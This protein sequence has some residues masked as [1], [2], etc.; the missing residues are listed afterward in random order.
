M[1]R[2]DARPGSRFAIASSPD[3]QIAV[4]DAVG[5]MLHRDDGALDVVLPHALYRVQLERAGRVTSRL[6]DH[7]DTTE[8]RL[9]GPG[10]VTPVPILGAITSHD[11][12]ADAAEQVSVSNTSAPLGPPPHDSRLFVFLRREAADRGPATLPS[13]PVTLHDVTGRKLTALGHA[14]A[15]VDQRLGYIAFATWVASGTY[16]LR[17]GR[18]R[19]DI[20]ITI[21]PGRAAHVF[22]ADD[23]EL[24]LD[25]CRIALRPVDQRF[26]RRSNTAREVEAVV[27]AL[28]ARDRALPSSAH[29]LLTSAIDDDLC[30]GI[31]AAH[32]LLRSRELSALHTL[33]L[34]LGRIADAIPDVAVLDRVLRRAAGTPVDHLQLAAPPLLRASLAL[35]MCCGQSPDVD[36]APE[37][38]VVQ[39]ALAGYHDSIWC[40]WSDRAWDRRWVEATIDALR[41]GRDGSDA[42][43]IARSIAVPTRTVHET[44]D[45]IAASLPSPGGAADP[46]APPSVP[47]YALGDVIG[48]G[49][50]GTVFRATRVADRCAV[51]LKVVP[52]SASRERRL[53]A[54]RELAL[55]RHIDHTQIV[56]PRACGMLPGDAGCWFEFE[57]CR[58][59][60]LDLLA[61]ADAA[62][63]PPRACAIALQALEGLAHLHARGIVHRDIK[64]GNLLIRADGSAAIADLGLAKL[65]DG[66][67]VSSPGTAGGT[68][69]FAPREQLL[70]FKRASPAADV[71]SM[72][73][74]LYFML[75]L[76]PPRETFTDQGELE[77]A[78]ENPVVAIEDRLP[79][80]PPLLAICIN[81]ALSIDPVGRPRD[82]AA[83]RAD[84]AAAAA[85]R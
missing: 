38:A 84:L 24:R 50:Q 52:L 61:A 25:A 68:F 67:S 80:I 64:P 66:S 76:D 20:A 47:G 13:E 16:R 4:Y 42:L 72:A 83:F 45:G 28:G 59:S 14:T 2:S 74:T 56:S 10:L 40:T 51:A 19:R 69:G 81:R 29:Q 57:L 32:L 44:I 8:L 17:A 31:A 78:L 7:A 33:M 39:A 15:V 3:V 63:P 26:D 21:P 11:Y 46:A 75:S 49:G 30:F 35:A 62:L 18:T 55:V 36:V 23:G 79:G 12:Y 73:A 65:V 71:W 53:R 1:S 43:A 77:A 37:G 54:T 9:P 85:A 34:H 41:T 58:G 70:D 60:V 27:A 6:I 22:I 48:R 82:A 5:S